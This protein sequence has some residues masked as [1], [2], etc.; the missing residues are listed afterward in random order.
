MNSSMNNMISKK[1]SLYNKSFIRKDYEQMF[2]NLNMEEL[3]RP[4][5]DANN[6]EI[7]TAGKSIMNPIQ[8]D[9]ISQ[10]G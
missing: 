1:N 10:E 8:S 5:I 4:R 2:M 7:G 9:I 3:M 6:N